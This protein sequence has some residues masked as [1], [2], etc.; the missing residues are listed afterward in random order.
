MSYASIP[1]IIAVH[2]SLNSLSHSWNNH[3]TA[4]T[5]RFYIKTQMNKQNIITILYTSPI[6]PYHL[7]VL[8]LHLWLCSQF[9]YQVLQ[10]GSC[11]SKM[12]TLWSL[13]KLSVQN[14][15]VQP[16]TKK[17]RYF[18]SLQ[19]LCHTDC[20]LGWI[21][22]RWQ[23]IGWSTFLFNGVYHLQTHIYRTHC[24]SALYAQTLRR[25]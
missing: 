22:I 2:S 24:H 5:I 20:Q 8:N 16:S 9:N 23:W 1:P 25:I 3:N 13:L 19:L 11:L 15:S 4:T 17:A 18:F 7:W 21:T 10:L 6:Y 14:N 12:N